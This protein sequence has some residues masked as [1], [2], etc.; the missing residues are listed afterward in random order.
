MGTKECG[1]TLK[2]IQIL[3]DGRV[4]AKDAK[5]RKMEGKTT[6]IIGRNTEGCQMNLK[7]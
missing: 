1:N 2:R 7:V 4:S 6:R 5:D 3:E